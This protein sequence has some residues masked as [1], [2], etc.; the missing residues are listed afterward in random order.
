MYSKAYI[1]LFEELSKLSTDRSIKMGSVD[2]LRKTSLQYGPRGGSSAI[3]NR[4]DSL[5]VT[6]LLT[7]LVLSLLG[8]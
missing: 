5:K 2:W 4:I 1:N 3:S 6:R 7:T 8:G